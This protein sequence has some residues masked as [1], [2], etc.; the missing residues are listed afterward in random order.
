M[1]KVASG[2]D[3]EVCLK[4]CD[5]ILSRVDAA[6]NERYLRADVTRGVLHSDAVMPEHARAAERLKKHPVPLDPDGCGHV[7][8]MAECHHPH[9]TFI[10]PASLGSTR[11]IF[12]V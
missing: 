5:L 3:A 6:Q 7:I 2:M 11:Y 10:G 8:V 1:G 12:S 9:L 4:V